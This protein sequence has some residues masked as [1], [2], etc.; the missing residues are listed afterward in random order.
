MFSLLNLYSLYIVQA[1]RL[2]VDLC[3]FF[4]DLIQY[5]KV[6]A[7]LFENILVFNIYRS[8]WIISFFL[9]LI[10]LIKIF[11]AVAETNQIYQLITD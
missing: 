9:N 11:V 2:T 7:A 5:S 1:E 10:K 4:R 6:S 8:D 3:K